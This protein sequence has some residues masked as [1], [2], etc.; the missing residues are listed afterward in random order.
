MTKNPLVAPT[1]RVLQT[2]AHIS[3]RDLACAWEGPTEPPSV[4][5]WQWV[6]HLSL[7]CGWCWESMKFSAKRS[8]FGT[9]SS[10]LR[11]AMEKVFLS[12]VEDRNR[13]APRHRAALRAAKGG[14]PELCMLLLEEEAAAN[15]GGPAPGSWEYFWF[16]PE[17][18]ALAIADEPDLAHDLIARYLVLTAANLCLRR[19]WVAAN[20]AVK[21]ARDYAAAGRGGP[22]PRAS[23]LEAAALVAAGRANAGRCLALV[24]DS[25]DALAR[26]RPRDRRAEVLLNAAV[27]LSRH[28]ESMGEH[29]ATLLRRAAAEIDRVDPAVNPELRARI[30]HLLAA[31]AG[32]SEAEVPVTTPPE[33]RARKPRKT[34]AAGRYRLYEPLPKKFHRREKQRR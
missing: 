28:G 4:I 33:P 18:L 27:A 23:V 3:V 1:D 16:P 30:R 12:S 21:L 20:R 2:I 22:E 5:E 9:W 15:V 6:V 11:S 7:G 25:L 10:R 17:I 13:L 34:T 32:S 29:A 31:S 26:Y 14:G 19:K 24:D 8:I